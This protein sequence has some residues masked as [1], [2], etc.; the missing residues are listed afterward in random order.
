MSYTFRIVAR[1]HEKVYQKALS[2]KKYSLNHLTK[3][4]N[5]V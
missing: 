3:F 5:R 1:K 2:D 4:I